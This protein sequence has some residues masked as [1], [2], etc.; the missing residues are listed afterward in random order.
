MSDIKY[1]DNGTATARN[2]NG[3]TMHSCQYCETWFIP[4]R[5]FMQKYCCESCRVL[6]CKK[7]KQT[8]FGLQGGNLRDGHVTNKELYG[9]IDNLRSELKEVKFENNQ[10]K[11]EL[12]LLM[13]EKDLNR[14]KDGLDIKNELNSI[15]SRQGWHIFASIVIPLIAPGLKELATNLGDS[16]NPPENLNKF[17]T[18][19]EPVMKGMPPEV[20][21]NLINAAQQY[22]AV[23]NSTN[24]N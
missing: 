19:V 13:D 17:M 2:S 15:K 11:S 9:L 24:S 5:R 1:L 7:R 6:A 22:F 8:I 3:Q 4:K 21:A 14:Q 16:K 23:K 20:K 10:N 18:Q 12:S